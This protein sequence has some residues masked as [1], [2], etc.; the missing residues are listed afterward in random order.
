MNTYD[1]I[2]KVLVE[3][4]TRRGARHQ[5]AAG[6]SP[7]LTTKSLNVGREPKPK[8]GVRKIAATTDEILAAK[9]ATSFLAQPHGHGSPFSPRKRP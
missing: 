3:N 1:R 6:Q 4:G 9:L 7:V 8:P 5:T 2:Y